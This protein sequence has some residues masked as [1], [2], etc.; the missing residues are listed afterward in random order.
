MRPL[1]KI[2]GDTILSK[3]ISPLSFLFEFKW[4]N[5]LEW[6][7]KKLFFLKSNFPLFFQLSLYIAEEMELENLS[8]YPHYYFFVCNVKF[9]GDSISSK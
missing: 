2:L 4:L 3:G 9:V 6:L 5:Q 1:R 8:S 7:I